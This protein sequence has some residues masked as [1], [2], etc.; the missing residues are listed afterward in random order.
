MD[1]LEYWQPA[2]SWDK[3]KQGAISDGVWR[4][5]KAVVQLM[6]VVIGN[7]RSARP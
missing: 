4:S 7:G 2:I 1:V 6:P 3:F 5:F